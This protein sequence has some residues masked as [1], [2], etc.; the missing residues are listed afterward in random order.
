MKLLFRLFFFFLVVTMGASACDSQEVLPDARYRL[1]TGE[2]EDEE[3]P[4]IQ[5]DDDACT[6]GC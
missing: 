3:E 5:E 2:G 6:S 4:I 1:E